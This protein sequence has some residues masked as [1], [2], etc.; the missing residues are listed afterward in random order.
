MD[1]QRSIKAVAKYPL[2]SGQYLSLTSRKRY[3]LIIIAMH[4]LRTVVL[5]SLYASAAFAATVLDP[6]YAKEKDGGSPLVF[7]IIGNLL[8]AHIYI[9]L[10]I[11][12]FSDC[13]DPPKCSGW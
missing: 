9:I 4:F 3:T 2:T 7:S 1:L 6:G 10:G 13:N 5:F 11:Y 8:S 12:T